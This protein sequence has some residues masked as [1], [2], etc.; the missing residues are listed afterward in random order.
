MRTIAQSGTNVWVGGIF[1]EIDDGNGNKVQDA[2]NLAVFNATTGL[3]ATGVHIPS[4]TLSGRGI[5]TSWPDGNLYFA[6]DFDEVDG[7]TRHN[8]A[9]INATTGARTSQPGSDAA[10]TA[11]ATRAGRVVQRGAPP[12]SRRPRH[13]C[14]PRPH[15][16]ATVRHHAGSRALPRPGWS[17]RAFTSPWS[18]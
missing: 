3:I 6:G 4:V 10:A 12:R 2:A 17:P 13:T 8:V 9:A 15:H 14:E 16:R 11:S 18:R 5:T 1:T 7:Q